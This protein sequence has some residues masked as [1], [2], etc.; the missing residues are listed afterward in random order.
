MARLADRFSENARGEFFVDSSCID[1]DTCRQVA[2]ATF[3]S[4]AGAEQAV[5]GRQPG[6]DEERERALMALVAC[7][8][9][10]IG[11]LHKLDA[12]PAARRF[13]EPIGGEVYY[14]G[15]ASPDSFGASSYLVRRPGG[16]LLIDSPRATRILCDRI[17]MLGGAR[18]LLLT[19][20]DDVADHV[21]LARRFGCERVLHR[22]DLT[23]GTEEVERLIDGDAPVALDDGALIIPV[24]GH[25][26]GSIALL[27]GENLFTGD[28]LWADERGELAASRRVCWH[29]WPEQVR[30]IEKLLA[31]DFTRILPGHG[32][33]FVAASPGEMRSAIARLIDRMR[34]P[35]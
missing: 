12:R 5:V 4:A 32:R 35:S 13:P 28:H 30:S 7:P 20:R 2:P 23:R 1:C 26:R 6:S 17:K 19:H 27:S 14:C 24:P 22:A 15:Y 34:R 11:T 16:N 18:W 33:R 25:T 10:S 21:Q 9:A 31:F 3:V 8:T 29:S